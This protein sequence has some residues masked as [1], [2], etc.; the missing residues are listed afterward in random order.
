MVPTPHFAQEQDPADWCGVIAILFL[1]LLWWRLGI[2]SRIYFDEIHYVTA[3]RHL[4]EGVRFNPEHPVLGKTII[5]AAIRW[6]GDT[7][8]TGAFL[9]R[10][11]ARSVFTRWAGWSGS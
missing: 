9:R 11:P 8:C 2:P 7:P 3:A 4:N 10:F 1:A 6:L 5:A